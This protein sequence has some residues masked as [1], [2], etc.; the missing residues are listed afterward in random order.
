MTVR[1]K[2]GFRRKASAKSEAYVQ[3]LYCPHDRDIDTR[4]YERGS[5]F[6]KKTFSGTLMDCSFP[7]GMIVRLEHNQKWYI[8]MVAHIDGAPRLRQCD[9]D[10]YLVSS[11]VI[12]EP[13]GSQTSPALRRRYGL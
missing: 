12:F 3:V 11:G 7:S 1:G 9:T 2:T 13:C 5:Y 10:G 6:D 4:I 8:L